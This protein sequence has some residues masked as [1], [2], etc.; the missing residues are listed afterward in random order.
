LFAAGAS[1][2]TVVVFGLAP[3]WRVSDA[4]PALAMKVHASRSGGGRA[5]IRFRSALTTAQI[6]FSML[7]LVLAGLF[8]KSLMNVARQDVGIDVESV[9]SFSVTP[10]MNAYSPERLADYY[11]RLEEALKAQPGVVAVGSSG[12]PLLGNFALRQPVGV[13]GFEA[14]PGVDTTA[15]YAMV[16]TD[17][18]TA[19]GIPLRAGR[20]FTERDDASSPMVVVVN[21]SFARKFDLGTEVGKRMGGG[22]TPTSYP[23]EIV[24]I[25]A[26]AKFASVKGAFEP[27]IYV[28]RYQTA[29]GIQA[30]FYHLRASADPK[31]LLTLI[32]R[33][34]AEVDPDVPVTNLKTMVT[35]VNEN[36]YVDRLLSMLSLGF[37]ALATLLAGIGL[38]GVLAYNVTQRTRELGL[39]LALG[40]AP[41]ALRALVLKQVGVMALIGFSVGLAAAF[42][43]SRAAEALLFGLSARDPAVFGAAVG[44]LAA[45][46]LAASWLPAW[47]ASRIAPTEALRYE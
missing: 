26:D 13:E 37:A 32:P 39:R 17:F 27:V 34:A 35:T 47:R 3:A 11:D 8:T 6:A 33:V 2:I 21:E 12:V 16:G 36:V 28:S 25:V 45:V 4:N 18:F 22:A 38:Y 31:A 40:A 10:R 19:L 5:A 1:L 14:A 9:A 30:M 23:F 29:G 43:L 7:L 42:A 15:A 44:V 24:G 20:T 41:A 46:V